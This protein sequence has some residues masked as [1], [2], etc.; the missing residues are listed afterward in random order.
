[1]SPFIDSLV[2]LAT[3]SSE[4]F[5]I[6]PETQASERECGNGDV[7][8]DGCMLDQILEAMR[9]ERQRDKNSGTLRQSE[10]PNQGSRAM[11]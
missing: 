11:F 1:M 7:F 5:S 4:I 10:N 8:A 3:G 9:K 2:A 6:G